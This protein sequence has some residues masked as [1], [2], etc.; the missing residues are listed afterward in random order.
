MLRGLAVL[1]P[2]EG[3]ARKSPEFRGPERW[4]PAPLAY[5][6][7]CCSRLLQQQNATRNRTRRPD[8]S[9]RPG[10][11]SKVR[12][13]RYIPVVAAA[14][15]LL[16]R[17][18]TPHGAVAS[19]GQSATVLHLPRWESSHRW[20]AYSVHASLGHRHVMPLLVARSLVLYINKGCL[21]GACKWQVAYRL[22]ALRTADKHRQFIQWLVYLVVCKIF[23]SLFDTWIMVI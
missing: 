21:L 11:T 23:N 14:L 16:A 22:R 7:F 10:P 9:S 5:S 12:M 3:G 17:Q 19:G 6:K 13:I 2:D 8:T 1:S 4:V 20:V 15:P 18:S